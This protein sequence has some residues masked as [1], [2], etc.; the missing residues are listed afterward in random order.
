V[1][2]Y[3]EAGD[4]RG[5]YKKAFLTLWSLLEDSGWLLTQPGAAKDEEVP[6]VHHLLHQKR[7]WSSSVAQL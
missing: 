1:Q 2:V 5:P 7:T 4:L 3:P 6:K